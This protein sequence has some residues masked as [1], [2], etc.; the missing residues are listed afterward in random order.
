MTEKTLLFTAVYDDVTT[1]IADLDAVEQAHKDGLIGRYDAAVIDKEEGKPHIAKRADNPD[2]RVIPEAFGGGALPRKEL[3]RA[4]QEFAHGEARLIVIG[5]PPLGQALDSA[6]TRAN[7]V[8]KRELD[9]AADQL[10]KELS[11]AFAG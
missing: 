5:Q 11:G 7:K 1:A 4:A 9:A 10:S 3:H 2:I 8:A 6:V